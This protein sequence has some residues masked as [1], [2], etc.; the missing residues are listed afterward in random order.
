MDFFS[1]LPL[2][3]SPPDYATSPLFFFWNDNNA[4]ILLLPV[5]NAQ[6]AHLPTEPLTSFTV[7][8]EGKNTCCLDSRTAL[9]LYQCRVHSV[10]VIFNI[11]QQVPLMAVFQN[12]SASGIKLNGDIGI[13]IDRKYRLS[14]LCLDID[15]LPQGITTTYTHFMFLPVLSE[16][17]NLIRFLELHEAAPPS[18]GQNSR[19]PPPTLMDISATRCR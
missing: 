17:E 15:T 1:S 3:S 9:Y 10:T 2:P 19:S 13:I 16:S 4:D 8:G 6:M 5:L 7:V 18:T 14:S 11:A 12:A